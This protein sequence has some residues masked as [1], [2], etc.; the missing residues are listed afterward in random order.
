[1]SFDNVGYTIDDYGIFLAEKSD[2]PFI[3]VEG[4]AK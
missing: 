3:M 4:K 1:M 2:V